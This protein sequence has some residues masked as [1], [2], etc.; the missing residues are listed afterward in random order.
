M[1]LQYGCREEK[2]IVALYYFKFCIN[3][4]GDERRKFAVMLK[5]QM[6]MC[7]WSLGNFCLG[8]KGVLSLQ[9]AICD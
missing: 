4:D 6:E 2:A 5:L 9:W 3:V 7:E 8:L 1:V